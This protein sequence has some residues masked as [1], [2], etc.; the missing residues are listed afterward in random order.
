MPSLKRALQAAER[1]AEFQAKLDNID[2]IPSIDKA[3]NKYIT[4][5]LNPVLDTS[6]YHTRELA[7]TYPSA[8]VAFI[9]TTGLS[10]KCKG[11]LEGPGVTLEKKR[12]FM[13]MS[14]GLFFERPGDLYLARRV[15]SR[16]GVE[17]Y[18]FNF[19]PRSKPRS[20]IKILC[21]S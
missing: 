10:Y 13:A 2:P 20:D 21:C 3:S 12:D 6:I 11:A 19:T 7:H 16:G 4:K 1:E 15:R 14:K 9:G 5:H 17:C 18:G 8:C